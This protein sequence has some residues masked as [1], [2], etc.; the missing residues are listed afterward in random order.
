MF[1]PKGKFFQLTLVS[2]K[3]TERGQGKGFLDGGP[4]YIE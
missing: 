3:L 1:A 4:G 2:L